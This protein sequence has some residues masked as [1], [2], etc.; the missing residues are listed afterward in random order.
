MK[1]ILRMNNNNN[2]NIF[3]WRLKKKN[4]SSCVQPWIQTI[5]I[6]KINPWYFM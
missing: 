1:D 4:R 2:L 3:V 6:N 5:E